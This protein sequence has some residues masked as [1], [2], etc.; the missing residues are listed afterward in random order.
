MRQYKM[1]NLGPVKQ[2]LRLEINRLPD[3]S[4]TLGQQSYI[5][6]ILHRYGMGNAKYSQYTNGS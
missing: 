6:S 2:F 1:K 4:I 3:S 5:D